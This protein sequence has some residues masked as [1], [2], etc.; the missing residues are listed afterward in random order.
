MLF[1]AGMK[2]ALGVTASFVVATACAA[3]TPP[4]RADAYA[5][6]IDTANAATRLGATNDENAARRLRLAREE[7]DA[8]HAL[9]RQGK[10]DE[11]RRELARANAD[12]ELALALARE[13]VA[14]ARVADAN[15]A[16][17]SAREQ[18]ASQ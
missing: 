6:A 15:A 1:L 16:L 11:A 3:V 14:R 12:A 4:P 18:G 9:A 17:D 7:I 13:T 5:A 2:L 8:A 10:N